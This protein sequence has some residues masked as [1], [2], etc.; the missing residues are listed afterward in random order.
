MGNHSQLSTLQGELVVRAGHV[1]PFLFRHPWVYAGAV[2]RVDKS[3]PPGGIVRVVGPRGD[4]LGHGFYNPVG[5]LVVKLFNWDESVCVFDETFLAGRIEAA[6]KFRDV[7]GLWNSTDAGRIVF[8]E[9]DA[10]PG[11]IVDRYGNFLVVELL[12]LAMLQRR[13]MI[14]ASLRRVFPDCRIICKTDPV[15]AAEEGF[16]PFAPDATGGELPGPIDIHENGVRFR[17][18]LIRGHKTGF[19]LDQRAN[20]MRVAQQATGTSVLDAYCYTGGFGV[21]AGALGRVVSV[22]G[23]DSSQPALDAA[24]ENY[25]LNGFSAVQLIK[26]KAIAVMAEMHKEGRRF[27]VVI[28]DPPRLA[29]GRKGLEKALPAYAEI[30]RLGIGLLEPGGLLVSCSCSGAVRENDL[31]DAINRGAVGAR[32]EVRIVGLGTQDV[33]HPVISSLP[34]SLYLHAVFARG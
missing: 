34:E 3:A 27:G 14:V 6:K 9:S 29:S 17:V 22:T 16:D 10:L 28:L 25:Q 15:I 8:G 13:A 12:T 33:D 11:L 18:D 31:I 32:R 21:V 26:G 19:Y 30:N 23:I 20:R 5:S 7:A 2:Q 1:K 24:K 4:F